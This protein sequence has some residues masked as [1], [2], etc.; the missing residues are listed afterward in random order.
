MTSRA[1]LRKALNHENGP[2]PVDFGSTAVTGM[3]V[4]CVRDL[5]EYYGLQ[6]RPVKVC[7]PYQML[8][9]IEEDLLAAIGVD[10]AG[11]MP[12]NTLFGFANEN[13]KEWRAP[14][15]QE[16]LVAGDFN[17]ARQGQDVYIY[18]AGDTTVA[19]SGRMPEGGFFFDSIIRQEPM[20]DDHL[21]VE[22][23]L[24]EFGPISADDLAYFGRAAETAAAT[25]RGIVATFGGTGFGDIAL[26]PGPFLKQPKGIR[27]ITEWY[28]S[29]VLRQ[30]Y[31]R[32]IFAKQLDYAL[33]NLRK[34][35]EVA[36]D[37]VDAVFLC[38]TDFGTQSG[39]FCSPES[40]ET[41][42]HPYYKTMNDW[43]H[44]NTAWKTFKHSCGAV[45]SFLEC[46]IKS[47]FD[48]INP[49]QCSAAGMDPQILKDKYGGRLVFWGGGVDT[50]HVLPFGT[51]TQVRDQVLQ[52][53]AIFAENGG[54]VFDA[55]H[56]V[57]AGT[58]VENVVAMIDAVKTYNSRY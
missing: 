28:V 13:W 20:D 3:H 55:I 48:I 40:Y 53:C 36:G 49:V 39:T 1:V 56:N 25:G 7:E 4:T 26:L 14:W 16:L 32:K 11:I 30:D 46:F 38:G 12:R 18:P 19:P 51:P 15:G 2:V 9:L 29:I 52:R 8:G 6:N 45:E 37:H 41:L 10:T 5:R 35:N 42:W 34:I 21:N 22:D 50:Q 17:T 24:E 57:Q 23:N 31:I 54:F 44:A 58:P 43:I 27:D 33:D 47:G